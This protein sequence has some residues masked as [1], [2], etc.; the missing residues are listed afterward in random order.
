[1]LRFWHQQ[2]EQLFSICLFI[3]YKDKTE[4]VD[5]VTMLCVCVCIFVCLWMVCLHRRMLSWVNKW[6]IESTIEFLS[7]NALLPDVKSVCFPL[8]SAK[9]SKWK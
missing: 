8:I 9:C 6:H 1:M 5:T 4:D 3:G 2:L 7:G